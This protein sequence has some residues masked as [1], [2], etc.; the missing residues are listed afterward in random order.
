MSLWNRLC[1]VFLHKINGK[2]KSKCGKKDKIIIVRIIN[3]RK[4]NK[5]KTKTDHAVMNGDRRLR[6]NGRRGL[7]TT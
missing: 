7:T 3:G 2:T 6:I 5:R 4:D 1:D